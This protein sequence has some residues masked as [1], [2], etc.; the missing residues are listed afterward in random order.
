MIDMTTGN[1]GKLITRFALPLLLGNILQQTYNIVDSIVV[2][3]FIG[4][5]ALAAV[6]NS[7]IIIFLLISMFAGIGMGAVI[8]VSQFFG[9]KQEEKLRTAVD[10]IYIGM[11][12]AA[13]IITLCGI[14]AAEP[15]LRLMH[16]PEGATMEM[17]VTYVRTIFLGTAMSFGY[18]INASILQGIGDSKSPLLFLSI[19]TVLNIVLDLL[20]VTVFDMGVFGVALATIIAQGTSFIFGAVYIN[21]KIKIFRLFSHRMRF[22]SRILLQSF[23]I[24]LPA[25][26]QNLLFC[27]GTIVLQRLVNSY[28]P[29]FMAG[30][31][32]TNKIDMFVFMPILS[33]ANAITTYVGQNVGAKNL[34]RVKEGVRSALIISVSTAIIMSI[35]VTI[36]GRYLLMAF[37]QD[38]EVIK[39]GEEFIKRLMPGYFLLAIIF[40][41]NSTV[42]GAGETFMPMLASF[43]SLLVARVP[44]A[45]LF[46]Y[47][48]GR[49]NIFWCYG[50]GW[51]AGSLIIVSYYLSGRWKN[52]AFRFVEE[53]EKPKR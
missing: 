36:F 53:A 13:L 24:G 27:V 51:F 47:I 18:N 19:A 16:T 40:T 30:Y 28:G 39:T 32:A 37:T 3:N 52:K 4:S 25:G 10:T 20:F 44:L 49:Y 2:G 6:G 1:P 34:D 41:L 26:I 46:N 22:D 15:F 48:G 50:A 14:G 23:Q 5:E 8:L 11:S 17:S 38:A 9:A 33:F 29:A 12:V 21:R 7:G 31:S 35:L 45:Y 43:V 42:R